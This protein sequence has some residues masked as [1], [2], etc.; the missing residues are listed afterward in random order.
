[1]ERITKKKS[2]YQIA[3]QTKDKRPQFWGLVKIF[4]RCISN[5]CFY[6]VDFM[7]SADF[8]YSNYLPYQVIDKCIW[9]LFW[10]IWIFVFWILGFTLLPFTKSNYYERNI[11][12]IN[13]KNY[14]M[15]GLFSWC[16]PLSLWVL[17]FYGKFWTISDYISY[18]EY[19]ISVVA[20]YSGMQCF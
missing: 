7:E 18:L 5:L 6:T 2:I 19:K 10:T 4:Y 15:I 13:W 9:N 3:Q 1:M 14:W 20:H 8:K 11:R 12:S 16:Y 17:L